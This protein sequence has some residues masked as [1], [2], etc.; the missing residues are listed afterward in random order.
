MKKV[1]HLISGGDTGGAKTHIMS[2]LGE[3]KNQIDITLGV[4]F[5][6]VFIEEAKAVGIPTV[7]FEQ[8]NR[9]DLSVVKKIV[10]YV[11]NEGINLIH[12]HGARANFIAFFL[13]RKLKNIKF[14]STVHSDPE[15]D[16]KGNFYKQIIFKNLNTFALKKF[17]NYIAV[18]DDFKNMLIKRGFSNKNIDVVYNGINLNKKDNFVTREEFLKRYGIPTDKINIGILARLDEVKDHRTFIKAAAEFLKTKDANFLIGGSGPLMNELQ[19]MANELNVNKNLFFLGEVKDPYSF[20]NA[21]DINVLSSLSESFPYVILEGAKYKKPM[22]ATNVGGIPKIVKNDITGY[23]YN[24]GDYMALKDCLLRLANDDNKRK[25]FGE[26]IFNLASENYSSQSMTRSHIEIYDR[27]LFD[28]SIVL[29]GFYGFDN[30]GDDAILESIVKEFRRIN[31]LFRLR[32]LSN[33]PDKTRKIYEV[34]SSYRFNPLKIM[35]TIKHSDMLISGGGSLL[36]DVTSSR[37]LWYY[38]FVI[39]I[40]KHY[41]KK[42]VIY[43]NGVGPI[44][45]KFNRWLTKKTLKNTDLITL[46]DKDSADY[47]VE[48]G[49]EKS[50]CLVRSDPVFLLKENLEEAD[51]ILNSIGLEDN[52]IVVNLRPWHNDKN[53]IEEVSK[54]LT[55][56]MDDGKKVLLLPMHMSKDTRVL[57]ELLENCKHKNLYCYFEDM[58]VTTLMGIFARASLVVAMRLHGVIYSATVHTKPLAISYDPKVTSFMD[59]I[60]SKYII[61]VEE[62]NA[63]KLYNMI[64]DCIDDEEYLSKILETDKNRK[65][66]ARLNAKE[67]LSL[68]EVNYEKN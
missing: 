17:E 48:I 64:N 35:S 37:S 44:K 51:E 24:V 25:E 22:V 46:R 23:T 57:K 40:S 45:K 11:N 32:V 50:K 5:E 14:V 6:D 13:M 42:T 58:N 27:I 60:Q 34:D 4:F 65:E 55:R 3:M 38:L 49:I 20:I 66:L 8:K 53:T 18:S 59:S 43:A 41:N 67:A 2:L 31:P 47:L 33:N 29:S 10:Q 54:A 30:Q 68:L 1:L 19:E 28:K 15:L 12:C 62:L 63:D 39:A 52:F 61:S 7:V 26:N 21:I 56:L 9:Y 36:Q 16:F